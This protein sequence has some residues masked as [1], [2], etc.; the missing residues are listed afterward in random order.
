M[1][2]GGGEVGLGREAAGG[3]GRGDGDGAWEGCQ[4]KVEV[5]LTEGGGRTWG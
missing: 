5:E 2:L 1:R 3:L 4:V